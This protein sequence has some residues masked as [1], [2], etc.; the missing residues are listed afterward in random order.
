MFRIRRFGI[1]QTATTV[2]VLYMVAIAI[3][4][5]PLA[6]LVTVLRSAIPPGDG[7]AFD[8]TGIIVF[9]LIA[10]V[11]YGIATWVITAISCV[12]YNLVAGWVGGIHVQIEPVAPPPSA[13]SFGSTATLPPTTTPTA[14][15]PP[16]PPAAPAA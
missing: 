3:L 13:P 5:V 15:P 1:V 12:V 4:I 9:A 14:P 6:F 7:S 2:A 11:G 8:V 16:V 10:I